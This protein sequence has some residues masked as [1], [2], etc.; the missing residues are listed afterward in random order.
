M[1]SNAKYYKRYLY[2]LTFPNG[3]VYI[4][5]AFDI[6]KRWA[7]RGNGYRSQKIWPAIK[8]FGWDNIGKEVLLHLPPDE[9]DYWSDVKNTQRIRDMERELIREY[10]GR[11]YN[12]QCTKEGGNL[13]AQKTRESGVYDRNRKV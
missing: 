2:K 11:S 12:V 3:M 10:D 7:N 13:I 4:G 9:N 5:T 6:E 1:I 8:E